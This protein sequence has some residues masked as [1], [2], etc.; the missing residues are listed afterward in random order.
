[1][2]ILVFASDNRPL[3]SS[4]EEAQYN[5]LSVL[6]NSNYCQANNYDFIYFQPYYKQV[7]LS[8]NTNCTNPHTGSPRHSSWSKLLSTLK[9]MEMGYDYVVYIDSDAVLRTNSYKLETFIEKYG[10]DKD[11]IFLDN[12]PN[13]KV[14]VENSA[15]AGFFIVKVNSSAKKSVQDWYNINLP[16]FDVTPF[17]EQYALWWHMIDKMKVR[18]VPEE[19]FHEE[20]DQL[21]RHMHSG[22][23]GQRLGYFTDIIKDRSLHIENNSKVPVNAFNTEELTCL[24]RS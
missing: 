12:S 2:R 20:E 21:V 24:E 16:R 9:A 8:V 3:S 5:S 13:L 1:M 22:L 19:H 10:E 6:I 23:S 14:K 18:I 17:W 4:M 7:D 11:F 15:N